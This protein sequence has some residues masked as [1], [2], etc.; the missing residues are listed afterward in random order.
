MWRT[1]AFAKMGDIRGVALPSRPDQ[2]TASEMPLKERWD[3]GWEARLA[4][5]GH[6]HPENIFKMINASVF[7]CGILEMLSFANKIEVI[8]TTNHN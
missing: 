1:N 2:L 7:F 5:L 4:W 8:W 3:L 6:A